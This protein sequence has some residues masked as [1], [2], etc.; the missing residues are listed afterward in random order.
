MKFWDNIKHGAGTIIKSAAI[1]AAS[2]TV[3]TSIYNY[4]STL[5]KEVNPSATPVD[6]NTIDK[7]KID[8][9]HLFISDPSKTD[10]GMDMVLG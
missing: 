9:S 5:N 1:T 2:V 4:V 8:Q 10:D 7:S 6:V 3:G